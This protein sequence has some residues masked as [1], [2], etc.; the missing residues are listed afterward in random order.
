MCEIMPHYKYGF[1]GDEKNTAKAQLYNIDASYKELAA[2]CSAIRGMDAEVA[3]VFL[4][5]VMRMELPVRFVKHSRKMGHR[6]ELGGAKGRY[7]QKAAGFV[8]QVLKNAIANAGSKGI[9]NPVIVHASAN[10][11][12]KYPRLQAKGRRSRGDYETSRVEIVVGE[13]ETWQK[14]KSKKQKAEITK[15]IAKEE[16][17]S[18]RM[19]ETKTQ[20]VGVEK[21]K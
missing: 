15:E 20:L 13:M 17:K 3:T 11:Q 14:Y 9:I 16:P 4:E 2:A 8:L 1:Q 6:K 19:K 10:H 21:K 12:S 7:P 5:K 18:E